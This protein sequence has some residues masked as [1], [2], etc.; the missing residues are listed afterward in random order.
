MPLVPVTALALGVLFLVG[1]RIAFNVVESNVIDVGYASVV[2]ADVI[3]G[4]NGLY[5]DSFPEDLGSGD[6]YGAVNYLAYLPFE[7]IFP[8]GGDWDE[9]PA[10]HAAAIAFDALTI[11]G[12]FLLGRRLRAGPEGRMLGVA[13]AFA[14]ASYPYTAFVLESNANDT[15][16]A[17]LMVFALLAVTSAPARG[18]SSAWPGR[19]SSHRWRWPRCSR[20]GPARDRGTPGTRRRCG[21]APERRREDRPA[22]G[23]LPGSWPR[24]SL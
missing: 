3:A 12:L 17:M 21:G 19:R 13:L 23:T 16:V 10:A 1:F 11:L 20:G 15:L 18:S 9:L 7:Q 6:T 4:G 22:Q 14:W 8:W 5:D 24:A 2:G